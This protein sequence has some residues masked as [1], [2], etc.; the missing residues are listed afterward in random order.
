MKFIIMILLYSEQVML[1]T[2]NKVSLIKI[3]YIILDYQF[4]NNPVHSH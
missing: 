4:V 1:H 2:T 3:T